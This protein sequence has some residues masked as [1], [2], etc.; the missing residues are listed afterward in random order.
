MSQLVSLFL[1]YSSGYPGEV[2][3]TL[4]PVSVVPGAAIER[5]YQAVFFTFFVMKELPVYNHHIFR[6][7]LHKLIMCI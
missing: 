1:G 3:M 6:N 2:I 7:L 5:R 4:E